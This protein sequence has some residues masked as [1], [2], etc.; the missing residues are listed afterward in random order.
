MKN[1]LSSDDF[2]LHED[3]RSGTAVVIIEKGDKA[4][5]SILTCVLNTDR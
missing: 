3:K 1:C 4:C 2:N 5:L